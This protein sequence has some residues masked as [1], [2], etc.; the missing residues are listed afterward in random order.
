MYLVLRF[1]FRSYSVLD[2]VV[3]WSRSNRVLVLFLGLLSLGSLSLFLIPRVLVLFLVPFFN[4]SLVCF[5]PGSVLGFRGSVLGS[6][7]LY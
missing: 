3:S 2:L 5:G 4:P 7:V 1:I 6:V